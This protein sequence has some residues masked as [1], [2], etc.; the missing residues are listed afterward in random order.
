MK[1][2]GLY[3]APSQLT[4][5]AA[6]SYVEDLPRDV[7]GAG[8]D[9]GCCSDVAGT[10]QTDGDFDGLG[11]S[12]DPNPSDPDTFAPSISPLAQSVG[13][14]AATLFWATNEHSPSVVHFGLAAEEYTNTVED[15][16][17]KTSHSLQLQGLTNNTT[18]HYEILATDAAGNT[19]TTGDPTFRTRAPSSCGLLGPEL[20]LVFLGVR[21]LRARRRSP[22]T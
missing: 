22:A 7:D 15:L 14:A 16:A 4:L 21:H 8:P 19:S 20:L 18:Y 17:P 2:G 3:T 5:N 6:Q 10:D 12:C 9:V 13:A 1:N 11:D